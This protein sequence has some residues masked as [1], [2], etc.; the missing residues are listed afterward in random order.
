MI[1]CK[2]SGGVGIRTYDCR[3]MIDGTP[4]PAP[5]SAVP[6]FADSSGYA[7]A[8]RLMSRDSQFVF[9]QKVGQPYAA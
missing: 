4:C 3:I 2:T 6:A 9:V 8:F 1:A 5:T 7:T